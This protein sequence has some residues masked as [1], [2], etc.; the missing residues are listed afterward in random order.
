MFD[1]KTI[2]KT[3]ISYNHCGLCGRVPGANEEPNRAPLRWW[4]CDDGWRITTLCRWCWDDVKDALPRMGDYA[5]H[6]TNGVVD[7]ENTDEDIIGLLTDLELEEG[8][9]E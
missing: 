7:D 2:G 8:E 5:Y 4:D 6:I 9:D 3:R 1:P